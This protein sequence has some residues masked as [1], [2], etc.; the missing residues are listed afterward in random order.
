MPTRQCLTRQF[1]RTRFSLHRNFVYRAEMLALL[2]GQNLAPSELHVRGC[3]LEV[4]Q[5]VLN[6]KRVRVVF[7]LE[8]L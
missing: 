2:L 5:P 1:E 6:K 7:A 3:D 4:G 8:L